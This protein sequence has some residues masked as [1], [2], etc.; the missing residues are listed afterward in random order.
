MEWSPCGRSAHR[1]L[2]EARR[3]AGGGPGIDP[4]DEL[5]ADRRDGL[6]LLECRAVAGDGHVVDLHELAGPFGALS[7]S[8][9]LGVAVEGAPPLR[10]RAPAAEGAGPHAA[11]PHTLFEDA[12]DGGFGERQAVAGE[13]DAQPAPAP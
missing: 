9:A 4:G 12:P 2:K 7:V 13:H 10:A 1:G 6:E 3:A 11:E 5:F 8:P